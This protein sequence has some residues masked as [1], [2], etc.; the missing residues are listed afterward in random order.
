MGFLPILLQSCLLFHGWPANRTWPTVGA[1]KHTHT[2]KATGSILM[3]PWLC[4]CVSLLTTG[5]R[6]AAAGRVQTYR[7][8]A[9]TTR[10]LFSLFSVFSIIHLIFSTI[11]TL[12]GLTHSFY[13]T[14]ETTKV[15]DV[16]YFF[17]RTRDPIYKR[18][19]GKYRSNQCREIL[20][21]CS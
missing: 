21:R 7:L 6:E 2:K 18:S 4:V 20:S 5:I 15:N 16:R 10:D 19:R 1:H 17:F 3:S 13:A 8:V 9:L 14:Y 12:I 11:E